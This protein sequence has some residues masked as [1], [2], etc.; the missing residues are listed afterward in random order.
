MANEDTANEDTA[1]Q[2]GTVGP[3]GPASMFTRRDGVDASRL[4]R[5]T[6]RPSESTVK[7]APKTPRRPIEPGDL[8]RLRSVT[9]V[10]LHPGGRTVV[11][12]VSWPDKATD[13]N[14][15]QLYSVELEG[16]GVRQLTFGHRDS[17]AVFSPD[18]TRLAFLR[19]EPGRPT[20][21]MVLRWPIAEVSE[22]TSFA[23]GAAWLDWLDDGRLVVAATQRPPDQVGLSD[24][25]VARRPRI[26]R[27]VDYRFDGRGYIND[28]PQQLF[29]LEA[30]AE[31]EPVPLGQSGVDHGSA[32]V[33]PDGTMV[34]A[35]AGTDPDADLTGCNHIWV[36][37]TD[38]ST[39]PRR[40]T[41]P[42]GQWESLC[43]HPDGALVAFG[44]T[45]NSTT[46]FNHPHLVDV[47]TSAEQ[48]NTRRLGAHDFNVAQGMLSGRCTAPVDGGLL[49]PGVRAGRVAID[50]YDFDTGDRTVIHE[51]PHQ[52]LAFDAAP[53]L[54]A[55]VAAITSPQRP[56]ELWRVDGEPTR[57]VSMNDE[58][59]AEL[60]LATVE[61][62]RVTSEP[63]V[64]V[65]AFVIRPPASAP[66][67]AASS[68][69]G[70]SP[71]LLYIHGGP[72]SQYGLGFFDEFQ[73]A[74]A[75]GYVVVA[76]NP[77]G[78]D[79]YGEA[80]A[81]AI[82][83][84]LG[85]RDWVDVAALAD[86][87]EAL[88][89]V[90]PD[91]LGVGGGSYGGFMTGWALSHDNRFKAGL[92]ERAVTS[93]NSFSRTSDIGPWF[94]AK[95][96]GATLEN[97]PDAVTR[98]S[99]LHYAANITAPTLIVH[100]E[101]DWRCPIEQGEQLFAAIRRAGGDVTMVRFPDESHGLTRGGGP[102]H[103]VER[104][105]IVHEFFAHHLG[106]ADF[107]TDHLGL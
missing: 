23:D 88:P 103:R 20:S 7:T 16:N 14:R 8:H 6:T 63:G 2:D 95:T 82:I 55:A 52:V 102:V 64:D 12:Q 29:L 24:D 84:D 60:D 77:R 40:L 5:V 90:D 22:I 33:S 69:D 47:S 19:S 56:A 92:V 105:E 35:V 68:P 10:A 25:D 31:P 91:R 79:G 32:A 100:S 30:K 101:H 49:T 11:Y 61:E 46:G 107:G 73:M 57:L 70:G 38:G 66:S 99:P 45:D 67:S 15:A 89:E 37:R 62:V 106:G 36:Y 81:Q 76:G 34:A 48:P 78:S 13:S 18:G 80:W 93:W 39:A 53:D 1:N 54:S 74:A 72:M 50:R 27:S 75:S 9:D 28:R 21:V 94:T 43:W 71:G 4:I 51:G 86:H 26:V 59:L 42:G 83:G 3:R 44:K 98:Q 41:G 17:A 87:L 85:N 58:L 104:F 96:I 97:D 65:H